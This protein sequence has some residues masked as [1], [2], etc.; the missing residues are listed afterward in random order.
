MLTIEQQQIVKEVLS[1]PAFNFQNYDGNDF[2]NEEKL[3]MLYQAVEL[4]LQA[5]D[6]RHTDI[7]FPERIQYIIAEGV[8]NF[9]CNFNNIYNTIGKNCKDTNKTFPESELYG[10]TAYGLLCTEYGSNCIGMTE[11]CC[12]LLNLKGYEATPLISKLLKGN[13]TFCHYV[14]AVADDDG[15]VVVIDPE[16]FRSCSEPEK[17]WSLIAYQASILYFSPDQDFCKEK[18][19]YGLGPDFLEYTS[20]LGKGYSRPLTYI[21]QE[22]PEILNS[23]GR[24]NLESKAVT[25]DIEA[26]LRQAIS[27]SVQKEY[28]QSLQM[29]SVRSS[30][31]RS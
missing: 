7:P 1:H 10:R 13:Q 24:L 27:V 22:Y 26:K 11:A 14:T 16:R 23:D 21:E 29:M 9:P 4:M 6:S 12:I 3:N 28:E 8:A 20:R 5:V 30:E 17:Q 18:L 31:V 19:Q 25:F 2:Y 15:N